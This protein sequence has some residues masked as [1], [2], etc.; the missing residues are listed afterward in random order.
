MCL[1]RPPVRRCHS[2]GF[3]NAACPIT[4]PQSMTFGM[5]PVT[6]IPSAKPLGTRRENGPRHSAHPPHLVHGRRIAGPPSR[7]APP[8]QPT[9]KHKPDSC[10]KTP[11]YEVCTMRD[12]PTSAHTHSLPDKASLNTKTLRSAMMTN[13]APPPVPPHLEAA[14][15]QQPPTQEQL[16]RSDPPWSS[17][18]KDG[19]SSDSL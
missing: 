2:S 11:Q 19:I 17:R 10:D 9:T 4:F 6:L 7:R 5:P 13:R 15:P 1:S 3:W 16:P 18:S 12:V 8:I 14:T